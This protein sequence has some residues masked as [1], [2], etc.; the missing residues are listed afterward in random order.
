MA[1][2]TK[3]ASQAIRKNAKHLFRGGQKCKPDVT[4]NLYDPLHIAAMGNGYN[5][6]I[7][8]CSLIK[9]EAAVCIFSGM[10]LL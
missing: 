6:S 7:N 3:N 5:C 1:A 2:K 8:G 4:K 9:R 10:S